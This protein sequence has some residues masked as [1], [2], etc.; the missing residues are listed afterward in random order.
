MYRTI[1]INKKKNK[2]KRLGTG[3]GTGTGQ[4]TTYVRRY[5]GPVDRDGTSKVGTYM[6][7]RGGNVG[8]F[9]IW[10]VVNNFLDFWNEITCY[11]YGGVVDVTFVT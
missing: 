6:S 5:A 1:I 7:G 11:L 2:M 4:R 10:F 3:T 9:G 8:S